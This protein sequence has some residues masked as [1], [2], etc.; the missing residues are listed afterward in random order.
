MMSKSSFMD[1]ND[2]N[3]GKS[4]IRSLNLHAE[5]LNGCGE[6]TM[7]TFEIRQCNDDGVFVTS[8]VDMPVLQ[9]LKNSTSVSFMVTP[10]DVQK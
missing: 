7:Q 9:K 3:S 10:V 2:S 8:I 4:N 6:Y 1:M 5:A